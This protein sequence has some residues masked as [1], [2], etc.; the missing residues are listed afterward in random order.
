MPIYVNSRKVLYPIEIKDIKANFFMGGKALR[1]AAGEVFRQ[2]W[3]IGMPKMVRRA[4]AVAPGG[5]AS[6][7]D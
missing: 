6:C 4:P 5:T 2:N 7:R 1:A 3:C